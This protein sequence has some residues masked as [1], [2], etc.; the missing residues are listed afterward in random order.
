VYLAG[1]VLTL[2][3]AFPLFWLVD[4]GQVWSIAVAMTV[5]LAALSVI[6]GPL[7]AFFSEMF[8]AEVRYSG[9]SL[10]YQ[11]GALV[12]GAMAPLFAVYL[13]R[14][15]GGTA[16]ISFYI[17]AMAVIAIL[18][19]IALSETRHNDMERVALDRAAGQG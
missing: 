2:L 18:C 5:A 19:T 14:V 4:M 15:T 17:I 10:S 6:Y 9:A 11:V 12:G 13:Q 7:A 3:W 1:T 16:A 8:S